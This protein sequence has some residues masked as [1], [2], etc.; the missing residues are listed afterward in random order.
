MGLTLVFRSLGARVLVTG[1][2]SKDEMLCLVVDGLRTDPDPNGKSSQKASRRSGDHQ[3]V[4]VQSRLDGWQL[5][6]EAR[7]C[8]SSLQPTHDAD[9]TTHVRFDKDG[10]EYT[11]IAMSEVL[12]V[13]MPDRL[14]A[15][16][17][18]NYPW[19]ADECEIP[20]VHLGSEWNL[21][22]RGQAQRLVGD[23]VVGLVPGALMHVPAHE[24]HGIVRHQ[25]LTTL[26]YLGP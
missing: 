26:G 8:G 2:T 7:E 24:I 23:E 18:R 15:F 16:E 12:H 6:D 25:R 1:V 3:V 14:I 11:K 13:E 9:T 22:V 10:H 17:I 20:H 5:S 4:D 21:V 19:L